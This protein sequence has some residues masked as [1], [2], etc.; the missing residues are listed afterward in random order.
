MHLLNLPEIGAIFDDI[1]V[2]LVERPYGR[3]L[4]TGEVSQWVKEEVVDTSSNNV[5]CQNCKSAAD[6]G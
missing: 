5:Y 6:G 2:E 1:V 4:G 3:Q